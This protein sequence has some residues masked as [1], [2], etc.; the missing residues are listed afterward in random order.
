MHFLF[1]VIEIL[2]RSQHKWQLPHS[3][4]SQ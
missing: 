2:Y 1:T 3:R 4:D